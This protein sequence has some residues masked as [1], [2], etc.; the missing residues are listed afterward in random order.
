MMP[1][2]M[3]RSVLKDKVENILK[4]TLKKTSTYQ[5]MDELEAAEVR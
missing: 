5:G 2:I 1:N 4:G 3:G